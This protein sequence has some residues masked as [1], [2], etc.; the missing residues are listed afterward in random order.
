MSTNKPQLITRIDGIAREAELRIITGIP[1][2]SWY[3]LQKKGLAPKPIRLGPRSVGWPRRVL[4]AWC[5]QRQDTW[6]R[7]GDAAVRVV[8]KAGPR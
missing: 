7:L 5:E 1:T 8:Q 4:F 2:S 6:V 3:L